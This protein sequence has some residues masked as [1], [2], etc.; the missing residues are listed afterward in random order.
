ML[1]VAEGRGYVLLLGAAAARGVELAELVSGLEVIAIGAP[2]EREQ[3]RQGVSRLLSDAVL[4]LRDHSMRG[5]V[6]GAGVPEALQREA[7]RVLMTGG[8]LVIARALQAAESIADAS[9]VR[10]NVRDQNHIVVTRVR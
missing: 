10:E 8:R 2:A 6:L 5:V 7:L 4:P 3:Q 1:G 9:V